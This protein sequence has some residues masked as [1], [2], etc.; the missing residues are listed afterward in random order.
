MLQGFLLPQDQFHPTPL[1]TGDNAYPRAAQNG[2]LRCESA[3]E[4]ASRFP[5]P[6]RSPLSPEEYRRWSSRCGLVYPRTHSGEWGP[7]DGPGSSTKI[8]VSAPLGT[9]R[10]D[11]ATRD[12]GSERRGYDGSDDGWRRRR[13]R[14]AKELTAPERSSP[15]PAGKPRRK[16]RRP[17]RQVPLVALVER[18]HAAV[19][20]QAALGDAVVEGPRDA[21]RRVERRSKIALVDGDR[22][23]RA[24]APASDDDR[25]RLL[26]LR[27]ADIPRTSRDAAAAATWIFR[28]NKSRH[29]RGR[30]VDIPRRQVA[31]PPQPR[32][33]YSSE[34]SR[35]TAA[36]ATYA[37]VVLL[38]GSTKP[39][40]PYST[41]VLRCTGRVDRSGKYT[42]SAMRAASRKCRSRR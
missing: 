11:S 8:V 37:G 3:A 14:R 12:D 36:A 40:R 21:Q 4:T 29:R 24:L 27:G 19:A 7:G 25:F 42:L 17:R 31:A 35:G 5:G 2:P 13:P 9:G 26:A 32:R 33:G 22:V 39:G 34:A 6:A 30:D 28:G 20:D 10:A 41:L 1:R 15:P 16:R 23:G 18:Q 38:K